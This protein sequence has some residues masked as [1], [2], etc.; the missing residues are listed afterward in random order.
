MYIAAYDVETPESY[1]IE[2]PEKKAN[3][4]FAMFRHDY[5]KVAHS[6]T[7]INK[8]LVLLNPKF[9]HLKNETQ[10]ISLDKGDKAYHSEHRPRT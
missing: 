4:I 6:L 2:M 1:L 3:E 8:R 7:I 9:V 5:E 10:D